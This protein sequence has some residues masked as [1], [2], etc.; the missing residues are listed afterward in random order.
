MPNMQDRCA[1]VGWRSYTRI[2]AKLLWVSIACWHENTGQYHKA[3][4]SCSEGSQAGPE[5]TPC[6]QGHGEEK[7]VFMEFP[8]TGAGRRVLQSCLVPR[9]VLVLACTSFLP[10]KC[11]IWLCDVLVRVEHVPLLPNLFLGTS[12]VAGRVGLANVSG[13]PGVSYVDTCSGRTTRCDLGFPGF[14]LP[15]PSCMHVLYKCNLCSSCD[16]CTCI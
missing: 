9:L 4:V 5:R 7:Q 3:T 12:P 8:W 1:T 10:S 14:L 15:R 6:F 13:L 16:A 11:S 2:E